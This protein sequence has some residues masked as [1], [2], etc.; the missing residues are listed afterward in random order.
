MVHYVVQQS[1]ISD[2]GFNTAGTW[3]IPAAQ[4]NM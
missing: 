2:G 3:Q 1:Y 4:N